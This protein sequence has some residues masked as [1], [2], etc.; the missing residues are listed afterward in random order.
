VLLLMA[1]RRRRRVLMHL[2][3][4]PA[5][6]A[7][8]ENRR[9]WRFLRGLCLV[10]GLSA[11]IAGI[12]GPQWGLEPEMNPAPGR[13]LVIVLDLSRS[14]LADD[15]PPSR[16]ERAKDALADFVENTVKNHGGHRLA[17]VAFAASAQVICP[18]T[19]DYDH[20]LAKLR[21]LDAA[22]LPRDLRPGEN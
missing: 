3:R 15:V 7:L 10:L 6:A 22:N 1:R 20:F 16:Q 19:H 18:L 11:L 2:G 4:L 12:A 13:D 14:M 9:Q 8:T 21:D 17:L 5:L